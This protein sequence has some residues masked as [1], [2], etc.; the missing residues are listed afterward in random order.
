MATIIPI[1]YQHPFVMRFYSFSQ[2]E[3][4]S[5]SVPFV[6]GLNLELASPIGCGGSDPM[7]APSLGLRGLEFLCFF[8]WQVAQL[9]CELSQAS[10]LE[11]E[12]SQRPETSRL[13]WGLLSPSALEMT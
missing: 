5:L 10:L 3:V 4:R 8:S 12:R 11:R 13:S 9:F 2:Q 7:P 6:S 1:L